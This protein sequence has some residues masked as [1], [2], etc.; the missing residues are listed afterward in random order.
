[1]DLLTQMA[2][3]VRVVEGKSLSSA[4]RA[5]RLSL[6]AVSRQLAA[7]EL[8]L[9]ARLIVRSTRKLHLTDAGRR[10]YEHSIRVLADVDQARAD[11]QSSEAVRG[12]LVVSAPV[13]FGSVVIVPLLPK[14]VQQHTQ[15]KIDLRL[16]DQLVDL[17]AN[18]VDLAIRTGSPPPDSTAF[19]AHALRV[20]ERVVVA[21]PGWLRKQGTPR[22]PEQLGT[23]PCLVQVTPSGAVVRWQL[24]RAGEDRDIDVHG[25]L[26]TS[27]PLALRSLAIAGAGAAYLPEWLV[28]EDIAQ[29][30]LRRVLPEWSSAPITAWAIHRV[31]LRGAP[32]LRAFMAAVAGDFPPSE[33]GRERGRKS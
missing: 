12:T 30:R 26:R 2:T 9:G 5:Q 8:E 31:E 19:V 32:R 27:A 17:V 11:V 10:W 33:A 23:Q 29:G 20:M 21:T 6:P 13:T 24:S 1:M 14:L 4:A 15:L 3:F 18:G 7:L 16:E 25:P 28:R 22:S